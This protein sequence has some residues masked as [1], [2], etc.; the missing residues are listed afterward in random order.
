MLSYTLFNTFRYNLVEVNRLIESHEA[1]K[2][3]TQG[4]KGLGHIIQSAVVM[5]CA[6]WEMYVEHVAL[7]GADHLTDRVHAPDKL[8]LPV[9]KELAK[10]VRDS[11]HELK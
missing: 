11:Q 1:L 5:L 10:V 8:P 9:Q 4:K 3:T 2:G 6:A 7:E